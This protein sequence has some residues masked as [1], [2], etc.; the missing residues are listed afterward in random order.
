MTET[1]AR[2][3]HDG[4]VVGVDNSQNASFAADWAARE[5]LARSMP[6]TLVHA[7]SLPDVSVLEPAEYALHSRLVGAEVLDHI[8]ERLRTQYPRLPV[9]TLL[10]D[11]SAAHELHEL[12]RHCA[13]V[14]TGTRGHGGYPGM[15]LGSVSRKLAAHARCPL[16]VV[17]GELSPG[18]PM[19]DVVV[20]VEP[21]QA[22]APLEYAFAAAARY[23]APLHAV[24]AWWPRRLR[25]VAGGF[26]DDLAK[27]HTAETEEV[28]KLLEPFRTSFPQVD[29]GVMAWRGNAVPILVEAA[30][31]TRLLVVG[32]HRHRGPLAV[33]AGYVVDGVLAHCPAPVAVVPFT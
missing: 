16:V 15:S 28:E 10:S 1:E 30:A 24:R 2:Q 11:R 5:A 7:L 9:D 12:S 4:V 27:L 25:T 13:L 19:N 33:G 29:V 14:V 32:A 18:S 23:G 6:L 22:D 17:R 8:A 3:P 31:D 26:S 21:G 20:G